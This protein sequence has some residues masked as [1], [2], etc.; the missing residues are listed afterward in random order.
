MMAHACNPE[1][2]R[3]WRQKAQKKFKVTFGYIEGLRPVWI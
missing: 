1:T 2:E 3:K